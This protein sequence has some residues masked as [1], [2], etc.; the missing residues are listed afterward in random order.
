MLCS[1][2]VHV[3]T[4]SPNSFVFVPLHGCTTVPVLLMNIKIIPNFWKFPQCWLSYLSPCAQ[5]Q[6]FSQVCVHLGFYKQMPNVF[7]K[8]VLMYTPT[9]IHHRPQYFKPKVK[10]K[11]LPA[12]ILAVLLLKPHLEKS[13]CSTVRL[14]LTLPGLEISSL[15]AWCQG[16]LHNLCEV[17]HLVKK[18]EKSFSLSSIVSLS[19]CT[20]VFNLSNI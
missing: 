14:F 12:T 3:D 16:Y 2:V 18:A 5:M 13:P 4:C 9:S 10:I 15:S 8:L 11:A 7:P 6:N 19:T 20:N 1:R 17:R